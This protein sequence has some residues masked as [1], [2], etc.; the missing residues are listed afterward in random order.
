MRLKFK[1][2]NEYIPHV[3]LLLWVIVLGLGLVLY[4]LLR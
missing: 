4:V 1:V 3:V 2:T